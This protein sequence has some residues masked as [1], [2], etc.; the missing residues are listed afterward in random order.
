MNWGQEELYE[1]ERG[2]STISLKAQGGKDSKPEVQ[3]TAQAAQNIHIGRVA[4][5]NRDCY[6]LAFL[7]RGCTTTTQKKKVS[8]KRRSNEQLTGSP[9]LTGQ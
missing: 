7:R 5:L 2:A 8:M 4:V 9:Q 1:G 6:G 3:K